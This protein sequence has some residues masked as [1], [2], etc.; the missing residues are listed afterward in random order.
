MDKVI[1]KTEKVGFSINGY[2]AALKVIVC[3]SSGKLQ[4]IRR[5]TKQE[6]FVSR[7]GRKPSLAR[8]ARCMT[9]RFELVFFVNI[10]S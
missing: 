5:G 3:R 10:P 7:A 6:S 9:E 2:I 1:G 8:P 4:G